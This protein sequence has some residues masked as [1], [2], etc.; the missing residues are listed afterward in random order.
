[1]LSWRRELLISQIFNL[2][3]NSRIERMNLEYEKASV[4]GTDAFLIREAHFFIKYEK[5]SYTY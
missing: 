2:Q 5:L 4:H 1:M 3:R